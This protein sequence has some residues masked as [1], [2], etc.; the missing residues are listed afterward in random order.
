M[1]VAPDRLDEALDEPVGA[2]PP[3]KLA[4][5]AARTNKSKA[6]RQPP[7]ETA[8]RQGQDRPRFRCGLIPTACPRRNAQRTAAPIGVGP[9]VGEDQDSLI[10][11]TSIC[12]GGG[13]GARP[14]GSLAAAGGVAGDVLHGRQ[15]GCRGCG[16]QLWVGHDGRGTCAGRLRVACPGSRV[17]RRRRARGQRRR[18]RRRARSLRPVSRYGPGIRWR[19]RP[20]MLRPGFASR[21]SSLWRHQSDAGRRRDDQVG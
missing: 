14:G 5:T 17:P 10:A 18:A 12:F 19:S 3:T 6:R 20:R 4:G 15:S 9:G 13:C 8:S 2:C 11:G 16:G 1:G 21:C 7:C